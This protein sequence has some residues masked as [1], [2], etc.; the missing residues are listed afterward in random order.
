MGAALAA[1]LPELDYDCGLGT[2]SLFT[3]DVVAS[4]VIARGGVLT[5][6]RPRPSPAELDR[7]EAEAGRRD[8]WLERLRRCYALLELTR[9]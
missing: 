8:W 9:G 5:L 6:E 2:A 7:V 3:T 4:P 1:G